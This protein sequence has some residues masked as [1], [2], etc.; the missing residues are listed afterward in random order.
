MKKKNITTIHIYNHVGSFA[1]D[2]DKAEILRQE[3][4]WPQIKIGKTVKIDFAQVED[5]TQ[6]FIHTLLSELIRDTQ[7]EVLD[8]IY[9]KNC[10]ET[11][12]KIINMVIDYMQEN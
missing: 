4:L 11:V 3:I 10:N 2:K 7:G 1:E 6:S 9:F 12:Q 8:L 5:I